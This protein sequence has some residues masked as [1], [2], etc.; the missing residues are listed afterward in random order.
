[1]KKH[2]PI[3]LLMSNLMITAC[4]TPCNGSLPGTSAVTQVSSAISPTAGGD[5]TNR[6]SYT[7][8]TFGLRF[9][10]PSKWFGPEEYVSGQTLRVEVGSDIVYPYGEA[11]EKPSDVKNSYQFVIQYT[12][13]NPNPAWK[14]TFQSLTDLKDSES[15]TGSRSLI[16]RVR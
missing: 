13:N 16:I 3:F 4:A 5:S 6:I 7:N 2:L 1:M 9:Q 12:K 14:D 8:D 10:Y 11:P 15:R